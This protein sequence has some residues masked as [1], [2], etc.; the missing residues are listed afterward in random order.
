MLIFFFFCF[1]AFPFSSPQVTY[2]GLKENVK[3]AKSG[4]SFRMTYDDF[5]NRFYVI[6][7]Y[8]LQYG[9]Q[10][11]AQEIA[12][13]LASNQD[14]SIGQDEFGYGHTKLFI[15]SP[16]TIFLIEELREEAVDPEG[17]AAKKL[18]FEQAEAEAIQA[19]RIAQR[20]TGT[21]NKCIVM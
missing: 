10:Q 14:Y 4:Y 19:A 16:T 8:Q 18:A 6:L 17:Y 7:P 1:F 11:G 15:K 21:K 9:G 2:L 5:V 13:F 3:V 20:H 12:R